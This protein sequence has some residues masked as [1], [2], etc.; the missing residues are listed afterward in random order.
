ML[1]RNTLQRAYQFLMHDKAFSEVNTAYSFSKTCLSSSICRQG[2]KSWK[3]RLSLPYFSALEE[4]SLRGKQIE[5]IMIIIAT[6]GD[7]AMTVLANPPPASANIPYGQWFL[8]LLLHF[9]SCSL[10]VAWGS[11]WGCP[12]ASVPCNCVGDPEKGSW[13]LALDRLHSSHCGHWKVNH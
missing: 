7:G 10:L 3:Y 2:T 9:P 12:K 6:T 1:R 11:S 8:S 13:L 5:L 4:L